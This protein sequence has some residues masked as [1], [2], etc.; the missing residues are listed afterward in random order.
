MTETKVVRASKLKYLGFWFWKSSES[1]K[2]RPH[3]D[4]VQIVSGALT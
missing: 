1:W 4:S 3:Q 2:S